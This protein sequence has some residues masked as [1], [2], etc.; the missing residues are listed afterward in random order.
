[1][2]PAPPLA[3]HAV[4]FSDRAM[5]AWTTSSRSPADFAL[6]E[7]LFS[8]LPEVVFFVKDRLGRYTRVNDA[9]LKRCG[10]PDRKGLLGLTAEQVFPEPLGAGYTA[11]DRLVLEKG[12]EIRDKLELHLYPGG[13]QGWC[14]T[15]K[16]PLRDAAG[17]VTGLVGI[18]RDLH[19]P[20]EHDLD[21]R[22][23]ARAVDHLQQK[24][25]ETVR[26]EA[27]SRSVGLSLD[28]F[29]RLVKRVFYLT[30]RQLLTKTRIEAASKVLVE[31]ERS[32]ADIAYACGYCD[33][34]AFTRQFKATVG[35]APAD[36]RESQRSSSKGENGD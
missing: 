10:V 23:L 14:L 2:Q 29:E 24:F 12:V 20:D 5:T 3:A 21:Y 33:H 31:S 27:L 22:R 6:L 36:F 9:L 25:A 19:R 4:A 26:L 11:Q 34:S 18:S 28:R 8:Q 15:F 17:V 13:G 32:I 35:V 30:P 16:M 7:K 1:V